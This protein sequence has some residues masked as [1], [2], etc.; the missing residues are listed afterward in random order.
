M[1]IDVFETSSF[2]LEYEKKSVCHLY[3][4]KHKDIVEEYKNSDQYHYL[5]GEEWED[6]LDVDE[7]AH[8]K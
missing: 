2:F 3:M 6:A 1:K 7:D 5:F 8:W 4:L